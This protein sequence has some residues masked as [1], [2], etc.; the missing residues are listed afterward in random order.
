VRNDD[1]VETIELQH[2]VKIHIRMDADPLNPRTEW[3]NITRMICFHSRHNLGDKHEFKEP[4]DFW[5]DLAF[6]LYDGSETLQRED[7]ED[8][9]LAELAAMV[10]GKVFI[11]PLYL[12]DHSGITMSTGRVGCFADRWDSGQV[13]WIFI[14]RK[15]LLENWPNLPAAEQ[16]AK[17]IECLEQDVATYDE[18]LTGQVYGYIVSTPED[19]HADSCWGFYGGIEYVRKEAE[20][21]ARF[22]EKKYGPGTFQVKITRKACRTFT[23]AIKAES[24]RSAQEQAK[25]K[26]AELEFE[27][28]DNTG[29]DNEINEVKRE[30]EP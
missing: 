3:D 2:G 11:L 23:L 29:F 26:V 18:Y 24:W 8:K 25:A 17:A 20:A 19:D 7:L 12:Y 22:Y 4:R 27:K 14:T 6:E 28:G 9:T 30:D 1:D 10:Q 5:V 21:A 16:A 15:Q 13:G